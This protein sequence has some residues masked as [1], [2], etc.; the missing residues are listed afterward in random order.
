M[1]SESVSHSIVSDCDPMDCSPSGSSVHEILQARI[2]EW[3]A[4]PFSR[5]SFRPRDWTQVARNT[6][7]FFTVWA[8]REAQKVLELDN[9]FKTAILSMHMSIRENLIMINKKINFLRHVIKTIRNKQ[10]KW[11]HLPMCG[12]K[13]TGYNWDIYTSWHQ[14]RRPFLHL[15][16]S[17]Q[18]LLAL[19]QPHFAG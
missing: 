3:V 19:L 11:Y 14:L 13:P 12:E 7:R 9:Y 15:I 6:G 18:A 16:H 2:L 17:C 10:K 4:N 8:T 1:K 5:G